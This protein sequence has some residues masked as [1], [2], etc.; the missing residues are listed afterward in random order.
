MTGHHLAQLNVGR[1]RHP[2]GDPRSVGFADALGPINALADAAPGF[3]WRLV[4]AG[5]AD[6]TGLRPFGDDTLVNLSVWESREALWEFTYRSDHL[7]F[8]R[9]RREWFA[10][11][12]GPHLALWW[13]PAGHVPTP[14]EAVERLAHLRAHGPTARA[15]TFR[16]DFAPHDA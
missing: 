7:E 11:P 15:F 9:S 14:E 2:L 6:A 5:G 1:L 3:V 10:P 16:E 8:L 4:D 12:G 13:V